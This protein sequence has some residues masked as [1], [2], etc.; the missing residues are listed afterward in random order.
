MAH[1]VGVVAAFPKT[2]GYGGVGGG[3]KIEGEK[4]NS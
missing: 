3:Y 1:W 4:L 2:I